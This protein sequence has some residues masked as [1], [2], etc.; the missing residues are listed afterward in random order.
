MSGEA[1]FAFRQRQ[2]FTV[3][4]PKAGVDHTDLKGT[5]PVGCREQSTGTHGPP[6]SRGRCHIPAKAD[7]Q[8]WCA[9]RTCGC[10]SGG[11]RGGRVGRGLRRACTSTPAMPS[12]S[13]IS[14][15]RRSLVGWHVSSQPCQLAINAGPH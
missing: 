13:L 11:G 9:P 6:T 2:G 12:T 10:R 5:A 14:T 7:P 15:R 3:R 4:C 8:G 1:F